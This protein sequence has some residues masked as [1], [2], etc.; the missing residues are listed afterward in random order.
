M[1]QLRYLSQAK[2][3]LIAIKRYIARKVGTKAWLSSL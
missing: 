2:D 3:D 1:Y